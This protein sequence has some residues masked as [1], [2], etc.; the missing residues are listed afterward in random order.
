MKSRKLFRALAVLSTTAVLSMGAFA[1]DRSPGDHKIFPVYDDALIEAM[2]IKQDNTYVAPR[3]I[4]PELL[5]PFTKEIEVDD[6]LLNSLGINEVDEKTPNRTIANTDPEKEKK[7]TEKSKEVVIEKTDTDG[8]NL[9][10]E[11]GNIKIEDLPKD[12]ADSI[13]L[14]N[15][16]GEKTKLV[17]KTDEKKEVVVEEKK[18]E[19]K[20][21]VVAKE[22]KE[23]IKEEVEEVKKDAENIKDLA[24]SD[25][26]NKDEIKDGITDAEKTVKDL[27]KTVEDKSK[28]ATTAEE[29]DEVKKLQ[30]QLAETKKL[31]E[32]AKE[33]L[34]EE[35]KENKIVRSRGQDLENAYCEQKGQITDLTK[36]VD[37]LASDIAGPIQ[38]QMNS[39]M[40]AMMMNNYLNGIRVNPGYGTLNSQNNWGMDYG[41]KMLGLTEMFKIQGMGGI[42]NN[43]YSVGGDYYGGNYDAS[44]RNYTGANGALPITGQN[45]FNN[46]LYNQSLNMPFG[47]DFNSVYDATRYNGSYTMMNPQNFGQMGVPGG[48]IINPMFNNA[49]MATG[50]V[51]MVG[52]AMQTMQ[53]VNQGFVNGNNVVVPNQVQTNPT[54]NTNRTVSNIE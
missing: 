4:K 39:F 44:N 11:E 15:A 6:E 24:D 47:Y 18:E 5:M 10:D 2:T 13:L 34:A 8:K 50:F 26:P 45:N 3:Y 7:E 49:A 36:K 21:E 37:A 12:L 43:Y 29:K 41:L 52:P 17:I 28:D 27:D 22:K 53:G 9:L 25:N 51:P 1:Q 16:N 14:D 23:E 40:Q 48:Q 33:L 35:Q 42:T 30:E 19:I 32:E 31:L 54:T 46:M 20:E 38:Q